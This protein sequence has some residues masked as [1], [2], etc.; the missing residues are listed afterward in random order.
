MTCKIPGRLAQPNPS[1]CFL[2]LFCSQGTLSIPGKVK[3]NVGRGSFCVGHSDAGSGPS[4]I[5]PWVLG[6]PCPSSSSSSVPRG[7][8]GGSLLP[9]APC[10]QPRLYSCSWGVFS[11]WN[12][13]RLGLC[14]HVPRKEL[15]WMLSEVCRFSSQSSS[16][17]SKTAKLL[18]S[19]HLIALQLTPWS[20]KFKYADGF[21]RD[22]LM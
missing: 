2:G 5:G 22:T 17:L 10:P 19:P 18:I 12:P 8:M 4:R 7:G 9:C 6:I 15:Q 14:T 13:L 3:R 16:S 21:K 11:L 20:L 1:V